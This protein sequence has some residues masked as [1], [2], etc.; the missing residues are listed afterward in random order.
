M[1][2][3]H[4]NRAKP[5]LHIKKACRVCRS[6]PD[7]LANFTYADIVDYAEAHGVVVIERDLES[8]LG[9]YFEPE[10][11]IVVASGLAVFQKRATLTH[12]LVH[13]FYGHDGCQPIRT[14]SKV[15]RHVA[16][17]L[18]NAVEF[19]MACRLSPSNAES[20]AFYLNLPVWVIDT[21]KNIVNTA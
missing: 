21:Y 16:E 1:G 9:A 20:I 19:D 8:R 7:S 3:A 12:E 5:F 10:R 4:G 14:E 6:L 2:C 11:T 13:W 18:I 17:L 15:N